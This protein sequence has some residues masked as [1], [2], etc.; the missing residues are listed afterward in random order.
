[1]KLREKKQLLHIALTAALLFIA[2]PSLAMVPI[3]DSCTVEQHPINNGL[4]IFLDDSESDM[5]TDVNKVG[6]I[7]NAF[8]CAFG[9]EAGPI[10]VS[11]SLIVNVRE[12]KKPDE[13]DPQTLVD[14]YKS[15]EPTDDATWRELKTIILAALSFNEDTVKPWIIKRINASLYLLLPKKYLQDKNIAEKDVQEY[16]STDS[17]TS[18]ELQLGLKVN[19]MQTVL[20]IDE[21]KKPLP[22]PAFAAY[23]MDAVWDNKLNTSNLFVTNNE[24]RN[25]TTSAIPLWSILIEGH[26]NIAY[27][28]TGLTLQQ[29]K[30]FLGFLENKIHTRLLYY[31]S[32][33]AAGMNSKILYE[34]AEKGVDKTYSFAIITQTLTDTT[35]TVSLIEPEVYEGKLRARSDTR[36]LNF[37]KEATASDSIN[38][39]ALGD[40]LGAPDAP[41]SLPQIK[42]PG[43]PWFSVLYDDEVC[44]IGSIL[45]KTRTRPLDIATFFAKESKQAAPLAILLYAHN[46]PFELIINTKTKAELPPLII[47]MI[48][49]D[50]IHHIKK[51]SSQINTAHNL[52]LSFARIA[53]LRPQ[54]IFIIDE[55]NSEIDNLTVYNVIIKR[56]FKGSIVYYMDN[57]KLV[58]MVNKNVAEVSAEDTVEYA[59]LLELCKLQKMVVPTADQTKELQIQVNTLF[60][61]QLTHEQAH[62]NILHILDTMPNGTI[63]RIPKIKGTLCPPTERCWHKLLIGLSHY[64][65]VGV[66]KILWFDEL[67]LYNEEGQ[68]SAQLKDIII[69]INAG[70]TTVFATVGQDRVIA[71]SKTETT[72]YEKDY[73]PQDTTLYQ[74]FHKYGKLVEYKKD[75]VPQYAKIFE[76]FNE[77]GTLPEQVAERKI[78]TTQELLTPEAIAKIGNVQEEKHKKIQ[79]RKS[80]RTKRCKSNHKAEF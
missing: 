51:L 33:Y 29:F 47:S 6:A 35:I 31:F 37:L 36:Y 48:P 78:P 52:M 79:C 24:Y 49:G 43:L 1:M 21:I 34:D 75:Y 70:N 40:I 58:K 11:A 8:L 72:E 5:A 17:I 55:V 2:Q 56:T 25:Y 42:F 19:H 41:E 22:E 18:V 16:I 64:V 61:Q 23:F 73:V 10:V 68:I 54:K 80:R 38:Y 66:R 14:R 76:Y 13:Q 30:E 65:S 4:L 27:R 7:S 63:L 57:N 44:S 32:C 62:K 15:L 20:D 60:A 69:D 45:T 28:I 12:Y 53:G 50:A 39:D 26:G 74:Y 9:Q 67:E 71:S 46:V 3:E 59:R 77:H